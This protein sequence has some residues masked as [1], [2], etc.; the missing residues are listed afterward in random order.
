[1]VGL[2]VDLEALLDIGFKLGFELGFEIDFDPS[3]VSANL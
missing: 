1:L 3:H 2:V